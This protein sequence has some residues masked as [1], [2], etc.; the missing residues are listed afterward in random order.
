MAT[1]YSPLDAG[2]LDHSDYWFDPGC[3]VG[4]SCAGLGWLLELGPSG[5]CGLAP[6][7]N[8]HSVLALD[9]GTGA[10]RNAQSLEFIFAYCH[11]R[12]LYLW[13]LRSTQWCNWFCPF[14][15]LF[16][17]WSLFPDFPGHC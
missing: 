5:K 11:L 10:A 3:L 16:Q 13:D 9:D 7:V 6:M 4:I 17:Y 12:T 1:R 8:G 15:C 2:G 14:V